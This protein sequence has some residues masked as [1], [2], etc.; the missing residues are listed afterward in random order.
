MRERQGTRCA[1][2]AALVVL[3]LAAGH[4]SAHLGHVILRAE[5]YLKLDLSDTDTRFVVSLTLGPEEGARI[6]AAADANSDH[7]VSPAESEAYLAQ[8]GT[9]LVSDVPIEIDG[10]AYVP[11]WTEGYMEPIGPVTPGALTVEI[12]AHLP[13]LGPEHTILF[14]DHM[15]REVFDRTDVAFR[16]HDG[17]ELILAGPGEAPTDVSSDLSFGAGEDGAPDT[18]SARVRDANEFVAD[19]ADRLKPKRQIGRLVVQD[20]CHLRHVQKQ[21]MAVRTVLSPVATLVELDDDGLCCGAG[22]AYSALQ[23]ELAGQVRDR[24]VAAIQRAGGGVVV[25]ANPGCAMHLAAAGVTVRHPM[26]VL[27]E[28]LR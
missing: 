28:A 6:L 21:H 9:G 19:S 5:R 11:T 25:S 14:R 26:D 17:A 15:R 18:F 24:K 13:V 8:W 4:A 12:T 27:A 10:A 22:G 3:M 16:A 1:T 2:A 23:P 20:P 7:D